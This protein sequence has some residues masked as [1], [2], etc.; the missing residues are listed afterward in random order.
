MELSFA[1]IALLY[2]AIARVTVCDIDSCTDLRESAHCRTNAGKN[3]SRVIRN[4]SHYSN[5]P[6][7]EYAK[8]MRYQNCADAPE[9]CSHFHV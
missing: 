5:E 4:Y 3:I 8:T 9:E 2:L 7:P 6:S 1:F